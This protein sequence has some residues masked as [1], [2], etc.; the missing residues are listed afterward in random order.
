MAS[1]LQDVVRMGTGARA[2]QLGRTDL[3]GKTGTTNDFIDAWFC[4]FNA[5][6]VGVSWIGFDQPKTLGNNETGAVAALPMWISYMAKALKGTPEAALPIPEGI[7][8]M[9]INAETGLRDDTGGIT[10]Y[11]YA[12][13]PPRGRDDSMAPGKTGK[14]VRDQLF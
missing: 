12:E 13:F 1:M 9:T 4:G 2:M 8:A 5:A 3:G 6:L 11:F 7:V 10:E 14:D